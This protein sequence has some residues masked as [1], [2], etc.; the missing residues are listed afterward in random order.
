MKNSNLYPSLQILSIIFGSLLGDAHGERRFYNTKNGVQLGNTR[1]TFKQGSPNV[2][3]LLHNWKILSAHGYCTTKKPA[4]TKTIAK[5][6]KIYFNIKFNTY[7]SSYFNEFYEAFYINR[8]KRVP[9]NHFLNLYLTPLALATWIMDDGSN[10]KNS[11]LLIHTN[12]FTYQDVVRL[13]EFLNKK[14]DLGAYPRLRNKKKQQY[15]IYI[16]KNNL[17]KVRKIVEKYFTPD[18]MRKL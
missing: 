7:S 8:V 3:Y 14:Y 2:Q 11:G 9:N 16:T 6:N 13:C 18:M 1:F 12:S 17:S 15:V 4:L 5:N 10:E